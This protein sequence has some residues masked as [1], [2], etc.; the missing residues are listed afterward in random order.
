METIGSLASVASIVGLVATI[1]SLWLTRRSLRD[2][3]AA[4][5]DAD[6]AKAEAESLRAAYVRKMR[7]PEVVDSMFDISSGMREGLVNMSMGN[8]EDDEV[9]IDLVE[10]SRQAARMASLVVRHMPKDKVVVALSQ[11]IGLA[12]RFPTRHRVSECRIAVLDM[13]THVDSVLKDM[14]AGGV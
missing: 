14:D 4:R 3:R 2:A 7:L 13:A 1:Y 12:A 8:G 11:T 6:R 5:H 9:P 10:Y